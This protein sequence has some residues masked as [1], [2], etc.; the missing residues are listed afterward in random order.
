MPAGRLKSIALVVVFSGLST[1]VCFAQTMKVKIVQRQN[2]ETGYSNFVPGHISTTSS[3]N[4]SGDTNTN[5]NIDLS[6]GNYNST[7]NTSVNGTTTTYGTIT[8][9]RQVSYSVTGATLSLLLLDG[10]V[11]VV[12]CVSKYAPKADYINR[13]SCRMPIVDEITAEFKGKNAK[14][15]WPVSLDGKKTESET[16]KI[17]AVLD[18]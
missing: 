18:K 5:G 7:S 4:L 11:A 8:P 10:R 15:I 6:S 14:L 16:Y 2:N 3:T 9:P 12:N 17:L 1:V 13:R